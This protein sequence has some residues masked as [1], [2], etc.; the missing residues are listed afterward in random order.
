MFP[1]DFS[2]NPDGT[3][4]LQCYDLIQDEILE[5][6]FAPGQKLKIDDLKTHFSIGQ[7]PIR[8]ALSRL[9]SSGLVEVE[10][11]KGFRVARVSESDIRDVYQTFAQIESLA[12]KQAMVLGDDTWQADIVAALYH[13]SLLEKKGEPVNYRTW[14]ERNYNFH[15]S[16]IAGCRSPLLL[17]LRQDV[18]RRFDRYCRTAFKL[19]GCKL[20]LNH[21]EHEKLARAVLA[22]DQEHALKLTQQ[23]IMGALEDVIVILQQN[24]V[25]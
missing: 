3:L 18:Y 8:E 20:E 23:H 6:T 5:G 15:V 24:N 21:E 14:A 1:R 9:V 12:L 11:N 16:L 25:I 7:S 10:G 19:W 2:G 17:K 22:R 13:L 4:A